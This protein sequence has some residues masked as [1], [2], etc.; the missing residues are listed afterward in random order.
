MTKPFLKWAGG[1]TQLIKK[2]LAKVPAHYGTYYEPMLGGGALF[3]ATRPQN[4][5]ISDLNIE[6][7]NTYDQVKRDPDGLINS[8]STQLLTKEFYYERR[9]LD[10]DEGF[11]AMTE[12]DRAIRF[13]YLNKMCY[14]G[15][16]RVNKSGQFNVP[17][18]SGAK[19]IYD[20]ENIRECS[21]IL[22]GTTMI[23]ADYQHI[24]E[25]VRPGDF[26]YFDPPYLPL[27]ETSNFTSY[28]AAGF[29]KQQHIALRDFCRR[30]SA[31]GVLFMLSNSSSDT[32]RELYAEFNIETV[33]AKRIINSKPSRRGPVDELIITNY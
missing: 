24:E 16:Y 31:R 21:Q 14:N 32:I 17:F 26:V 13:I 5:H 6:L 29:D 33:S 7:I 19:K 8:L 11:Q 25:R 3:F 20:A 18:G 1:K 2:L 12:I 27:N 23:A 9:A 4:A 30:L 10:R 28:T 22:Q 15:L